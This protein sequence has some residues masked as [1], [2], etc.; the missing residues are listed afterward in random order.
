MWD[1]TMFGKVKEEPNPVENANE[2]LNE[3][4][5]TKYEIEEI[6]LKEENIDGKCINTNYKTYN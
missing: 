4:E 6:I 1:I 2:C 5:D 3:K